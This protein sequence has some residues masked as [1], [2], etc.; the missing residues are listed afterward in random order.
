MATLDQLPAEQRAIIELVI[1]RGQT[2]DDLAK[3]LGMPASRV[4]DLAGEALVTLSPRT[5]AR[6]DAQWTGQVSDYM[7]SQQSGPEAT[8]TRGHLK[9]SEPARAW[10]LSLAD[11]LEGLYDGGTMPEV[12]ES[13]AAPPRRRGR[14]ASSSAAATPAA[15]EARPASDVAPPGASLVAERRP[16]PLS[17]GA[18]AAVRRRRLIFGGFSGLAALAVVLFLVLRGGDDEK[19]SEPAAARPAPARSLAEAE[20]R[21]VKGSKG[22]GVAGIVEQGGRRQLIVQAAQL[23]PTARNEAYE[24]WFY[25]SRT[26]AKS[27]GAQVTDR[28]GAYQGAGPLPEDFAKYR[29]IDVSLEKTDNNAQHSGNSVLR[30]ELRAPTEGAAQQPGGAPGGAAPPAG[31]P[32][33]QQP[34]P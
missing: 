7:L 34:Q 12:P 31:Q 21:P 20:L 27:V 16:E 29:R 32:A 13:E 33:P 2:Y 6:V 17:P 25:N 19:K 15:S 10:A 11:S 30:G 8:A 3:M 1:K 14:R 26:D 9:R 23:K 22:V 24:V 4:R 28:E 18:R 5:A